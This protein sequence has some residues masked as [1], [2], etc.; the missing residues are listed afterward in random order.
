MSPAITLIAEIGSNHGGSLDEAKRYI[1]ASA[2][3]GAQIAKFQSLTREGLIARKAKDAASGEWIDNPRYAAFTNQGLPDHWLP[4]LKACCDENGIEFMST[5]FELEAVDKLETLGVKRYKIASGD[6]TF[7]PL[8]EKVA[9]TGKAVIM[10]TGASYLE[11]VEAAIKTVQ[12]AGCT[13]LTVLQCTASYPP[14]WED[15]NLNAITTLK[16]AFGLPVGLSDH[17]PGHVAPIAAAAL[18]ATVIEKHVTFDRT[19]A[20]PDHPFAMEIDEFANLARDLAALAT[21]L[22][23]GE[24]RPAASEINRRNNLRRGVYDPDTGLP[25][26]AANGVWLRPQYK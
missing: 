24:K 3:A 23:D 9:A 7:T 16:S 8:L 10:S 18:G 2:K 5:P 6:L 1:E 17:S 22:G 4:E 12:A 13:D 14:S 11:E 21:A 20:G 26:D 25:T 19:S 15:L